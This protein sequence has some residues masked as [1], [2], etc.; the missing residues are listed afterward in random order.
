MARLIY[1]LDTNI[2]FELTLVTRN[3]KDFRF[4]AGLRI[5]NWFHPARKG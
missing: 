4:F 3:V 2:I 5:E 1:L